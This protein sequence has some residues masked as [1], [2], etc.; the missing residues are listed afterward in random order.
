MKLY[1]FLSFSSYRNIFINPLPLFCCCYCYGS[2]SLSY[3]IVVV[4]FYA[5]FFLLVFFVIFRMLKIY[6]KIHK[7]CSLME[8]FSANDFKFDNDNV[9]ALSSKLESADKHLFAF[10][11]RN[12]N[13]TEV[14]QLSLVGVRQY[15]V[16]D[17]RSQHNTRI[18]KTSWTVCFSM[19]LLFLFWN[20]IVIEA[21]DVDTFVFFLH[22]NGIIF[23]YFF[24]LFCSLKILHY[25][26]LFVVYTLAFVLLYQVFKFLF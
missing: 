13:W 5:V 16:K 26:T 18:N 4:D 7:F 8:Y 24:L 22:L 2:Y 9:R 6:R 21:D 20:R 17:D 1:V 25:T 3:F 15:V 12:L 23:V 19:L 10:D 14:F 11:M